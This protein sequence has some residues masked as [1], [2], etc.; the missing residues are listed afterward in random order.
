MI[1]SSF[2]ASGGLEP[3]SFEICTYRNLNFL[4]FLLVMCKPQVFGLR[5]G[6]VSAKFASDGQGGGLRL[7]L[8]TSLK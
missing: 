7:G 3:S 8:D 4:V 6:S 2:W 5:A 1:A